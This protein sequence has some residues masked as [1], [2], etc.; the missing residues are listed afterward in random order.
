MVHG[1]CGLAS[2]CRSGAVLSGKSGRKGLNQ[3]NSPYSVGLFIAA[4]Y[5]S[6]HS[7]NFCN[8]SGTGEKY[9]PDSHNKP[10][11]FPFNTPMWDFLKFTMKPADANLINALEVYAK[12]SSKTSPKINIS[13]I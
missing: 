6:E 3:F 1:R 9:P 11:T 8:F 12:T 10:N 4:S 5:S 13:S 7:I 2:N